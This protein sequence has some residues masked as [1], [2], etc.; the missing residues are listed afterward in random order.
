METKATVK[1]VTNAEMMRLEA[2]TPDTT[3]RFTLNYERHQYGN[4]TARAIAALAL[5][6]HTVTT[7]SFGNGFCIDGRHAEASDLRLLAG[8][9]RGDAAI[10]GE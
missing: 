6:G 4:A 8:E 1:R 5:A 10:G 9:K 7:M 3:L 2:Q